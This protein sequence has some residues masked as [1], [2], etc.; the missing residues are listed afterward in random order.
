MHIWYLLWVFVTTNHVFWHLV[1]S[2]LSWVRYYT[3]YTSTLDKSLFTLY[4]KHTAMFNW[5]PCTYRTC[6]L[7]RWW[8]GSRSWWRGLWG[9]PG[10]CG[11]PWTQTCRSGRQRSQRWSP[12]LTRTWTGKS[13]IGYS[14]RCE[15]K[16]FSQNLKRGPSCHETV[17]WL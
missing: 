17:S 8:S 6:S 15:H 4:Q 10:G 3:L 11:W 14:F 13:I 7:T 12:S 16:I 5:S 9:T 1:R 2:D